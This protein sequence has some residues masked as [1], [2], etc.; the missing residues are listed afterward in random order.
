MDLQPVPLH[1]RPDK[2]TAA[3]ARHGRKN[4]LSPAA[5]AT[6]R[7]T[8]AV[9]LLNAA[10]LAGAT[11]SGTL[12]IDGPPSTQR[13]VVANASALNPTGGVT[14]EAWVRPLSTSGC[15]TIVG[16]HLPT[17]Y[18][19]G[20]CDGSVRY[21]TGAAGVTGA[22]LLQVGEWQHV[23]VTFNGTT[24]RYYVDGLL[25]IEEVT[26]DSLPINAADLGIGGEATGP[27]ILPFDGNL[28]EVRLWDRARPV[29]EIRRDISRQIREEEPGLIAVWNL[30]GS[31][32]DALGRF[33]G[34]PRD[35]AG[36]DGPQA[37]PE[38]FGPLRIPRLSG[39]AALDGSC[40][41]G[42]YPGLRLPIYYEDVVG[43]ES[44]NWVH[45]GATA[46][47][48]RACFHDVPFG[49]SPSS[50][51][52]VT[53]DPNNDGG[54][55]ADD[56]DYRARKPEAS[57][58]VSEVG[59]G[60]GGFV[61][62]GPPGMDAV[63][64]GTE[65]YYSTEFSIPRSLL[66]ASPFGLQL[67]HHWVSV[68][69]DVFGWPV[70]FRVGVPNYWPD[71][72]IDDSIV[73][74]SD[75]RNPF[76]YVSHS[77]EMLM[78]ASEPLTITADAGDDYG[79]VASVR[80]LVDGI[81]VAIR[82]FPGTSDRRVSFEHSQLYAARLHTYWAIVEDHVGRIAR[83]SA[84]SFRVSVDGTSPQVR[85]EVDP[86]EPSAGEAI[87]LQAI[88]SDNDAL[89]AISITVDYGLDGETCI[90]GPATSAATCTMTFTPS[91][92]QRTARV[93][94]TA[95][96]R[97][98]LVT[99][100]PV[101]TVLFGNAGPDGDGDGLSDS[102]EAVLCTDPA[103]P[104]T[105]R[106]ALKDGWELLGLSFPDGDLIDLPA[107]GANPCHRDVF[108]Q[109]DY[110]RGARVWPGVLENVASAFRN[111]GVWLHFE[112]HERPRPPGGSTSPLG[113]YDAMHQLDDGELYFEPKRL[114]THYYLYGRHKAGRSGG[115]FKW[116]SHDAYFDGFQK[117]CWNDPTVYCDFH[118][119]CPPG[120]FCGTRFVCTGDGTTPCASDEDCT[121]GT[122]QAVLGSC[123]C[124]LGME[125]VLGC[126]EDRPG[127]APCRREDVGQQSRRIMHEIG[128]VLGLGHGGRW[129][130]DLQLEVDGYLYYWGGWD[131]PSRNPNYMSLM[132]YASYGGRLCLAPPMTGDTGPRFVTT[133]DYSREDLPDLNEASLQE[134]ISGGSFSTALQAIPCTHAV[135]GSVPVTRY[136]CFDPDEDGVTP[137]QDARVLMV[138]DG[139][140]T[141]A[142]I[143]QGSAWQLTGLPATTASG[144]DWDCDGTVE[145]AVAGSIDGDGND[146][147]LPPGGEICGDGIDNDGDGEVDGGCAW[148]G[149][150]NLRG[151]EDW[152][153]VP[154]PPDCLEAYDNRS[155]V[156]C[157]IQPSWYRDGIGASPGLD[158]RIPTFE[159]RDCPGA[160]AEA[161][162][163]SAAQPEGTTGQFEPPDH[164]R[165][166]PLTVENSEWL[167]LPGVEAC[168]GVDNDG[169]VEADEGCRDDD[170]D[171]MAD[172]I[173]NCPATPNA[174]QADRDHDGLG[175]ICQFPATPA[176]VQVAYSPNGT[177]VTWDASGPDVLGYNVYRI[178]D[179]DP[180]AIYQGTTYPTSSTTT[181]ADTSGATGAYLYRVHPVNLNGVE[182]PGRDSPPVCV[183]AADGDGDAVGDFCDNCPEVSNPD[184]KDADADDAGDVCDCA[185]S[186]PGTWAI[187][188]F[189][190][191]LRVARSSQGVNHADLS[192][193]PLGAQAGPS[194]VYDVMS[195]DAAS[196]RTPAAF[197]DAF[198]VWVDAAGE[199][200]TVYRPAPAVGQAHWYVVRGQTSCGRGSYNEGAASQVG[201][202]DAP[203]SA[204]LSPCI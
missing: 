173:D 144:I 162:P 111:N 141:R 100:T 151:H 131:G 28:A 82:D 196:L 177:L 202:R 182:G 63:T 70:D 31:A 34:S 46:L 51:T 53:L 71:A 45:V 176:D 169:D 135:A 58:L 38:P 126:A 133:F 103:N 156:H 174:D 117:V 191:G 204:A 96:D 192:W 190:S 1:D 74:P 153:F 171:G 127:D 67:T 66:T 7:A 93:F 201:D 116:I 119:D 193:D 175:D 33:G 163:S 91:T 172:V 114:W 6:T 21:Y 101:Q 48:L 65:F 27:P 102:I 89:A 170:G 104:D 147:D 154:S 132:S 84:G 187:P 200:Q 110:E 55:V 85:L 92:G 183:Q 155:G 37:P 94:A 40:L 54:S 157:Y 168:D 180:T 52:A 75:S 3:P 113:S 150:D 97:D 108:F 158:C 197:E 139:A 39:A 146:F 64:A 109:Y 22:R 186:D 179:G 199:S 20:L 68:A 161:Q 130:P 148:V 137:G 41:L 95:A 76:V 152:P 15:Q 4:L 56:D 29:E 107:L 129:G 44:V 81:V 78:R 112:E 10:T 24:R 73:P 189:V 125:D 61:A 57:A 115:W 106:D 23:A 86:R 25:D 120:G 118:D 77:P 9:L 13:V 11:G 184:Q 142:R 198:C 165:P 12:R 35:G 5:L 36:F 167:T 49:V 140:Q 145:F 105:D 69:G 88:A 134:E 43:D 123:A 19:L 166:G 50:F 90:V 79:D 32:G 136:T 138:T 87:E 80:I 17:G 18:W 181:F 164:D 14:I 178:D 160:L 124:P 121:A 72:Y 188:S 128:H 60:L 16:K 83:S 159:D 99:Q 59:N 195:G 8:L 203:L 62:G 30:V 26:P 47:H 149:S 98:G 122:C 2:R 42:E 194:V 185:P 143:L